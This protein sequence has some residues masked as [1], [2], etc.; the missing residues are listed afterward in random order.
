MIAAG[1]PIVSHPS[2]AVLRDY[3]RNLLSTGRAIAGGRVPTRLLQ[4][5]KMRSLVTCPYQGER[6]VPSEDWPIL[7]R[8]ERK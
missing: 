3:L 5:S 4:P 6:K 7:Y 8:A 2:R 1:F